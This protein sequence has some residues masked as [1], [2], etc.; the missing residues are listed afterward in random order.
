MADT[1]QRQ[2]PHSRYQDYQDDRCT[3]EANVAL[4][5][6]YIFDDTHIGAGSVID[7]SIVGSN[8]HVGAKTMIGRGCLIAHGV[9]FGG[10]DEVG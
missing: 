10:T 6:A 9:V 4:P 5:N 1:V 8:M 2:L 7:H 3:I